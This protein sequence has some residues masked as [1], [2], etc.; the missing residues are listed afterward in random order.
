MFADDSHAIVCHIRLDDKIAKYYCPDLV[1]EHGASL[2]NGKTGADEILVALF[3]KLGGDIAPSQ[4]EPP[5]A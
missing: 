1:D 3:K 2:V 5:D 4:A